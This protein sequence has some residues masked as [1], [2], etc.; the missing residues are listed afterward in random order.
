MP[1][2]LHF[3]EYGKN[4]KTIKGDFLKEV[5][6]SVDNFYLLIFRVAIRSKFLPKKRY[7][8]LKSLINHRINIYYVTSLKKNSTKFYKRT[9]VLY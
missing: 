5:A 9:P 7:D 8:R 6:F 3:F 1:L 2:P 4:I